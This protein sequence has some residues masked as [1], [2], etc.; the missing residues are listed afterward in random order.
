MCEKMSWILRE[1]TATVTWIIAL[2]FTLGQ[3]TIIFCSVRCNIGTIVG[4]F[5]CTIFVVILRIQLS[6][7]LFAMLLLICDFIV[8]WIVIG[9]AIVAAPKNLIAANH[10]TN[11]KRVA[12]SL[13]H[14]RGIHC[15]GCC[16]CSSTML[17][18]LLKLVRYPVG[19]NKRI[20]E[21]ETEHI[22]TS[23]I[24]LRCNRLENQLHYI[25]RKSNQSAP[26]IGSNWLRNMWTGNRSNVS[27]SRV[28]VYNFGRR[29]FTFMSTLIHT[30]RYPNGAM[31][32]SH[33][34]L[35]IFTE[36]PIY[37]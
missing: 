35:T 1:I 37:A 17:R 5:D 28:V 30:R 31:I 2:D 12:G 16:C 33:Q 3:T 23:E 29:T 13:N 34:I 4:R 21:Y 11:D 15:F 19:R 18:T 7:H 24:I 32:Y 27:Y 26:N 20:Q 14:R 36:N 10:T 8:R 9:C 25:S 6:P 22:K